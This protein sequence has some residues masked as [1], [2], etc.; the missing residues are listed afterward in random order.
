MQTVEQYLLE[1][2]RLGLAGE[3]R[4]VR[5]FVQEIL[6]LPVG[7]SDS[8][9]VD[10]PAFREA[11]TRLLLQADS[12][13]RFAR[14][15]PSRSRQSKIGS[16][17]PSTTGNSPSSSAFDTGRGDA[18]VDVAS[19]LPLT[20]LDFDGRNAPPVLPSETARQLESLIEER[21]RLRDLAKA[22][23]E[24]TRTVLFTGPPGVGKTMAARYMAS[25]LILPLITIDLAA[26]VSSFLGRTGQNLRQALEY[27]RSFPCVLLL[28]EF[29][30]LAKRRDDPTDVGELKRIVN[31]LL[32]ELEQW[33]A[34]GLLVAATNHPDLLDRAIWRRFE[35]V[36]VFP[37]PTVGARTTIVAHL[38]HSLGQDLPQERLDRF[39][40][41][42][43]QAS[44]SELERLVR[45]AARE[46]LLAPPEAPNESSIGR[47]HSL[48]D[49]LDLLALG[50]LERA[51]STN[52]AARATYAAVLT[53]V[54]GLSL[55]EVGERL[56]TSHT[57]VSKLIRQHQSLAASS[58]ALAEG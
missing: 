6:R 40:R 10:G 48:A 49:W 38:L 50:R 17:S 19:A 23:L 2:I 35:R 24:P 15:A 4:A 25:A 14:V 9:G 3:A 33:P 18:P 45:A 21:A 20:R 1:A 27:A 31:V 30:A 56:G 11:V 7:Q 43:E 39:V 58:P 22:G 44:G 47:P 5:Q 41:L 54:Y 42:S 13:M 32:L 12:A 37:M 16:V 52:E 46:W 36:I 26:V 51:A 53:E 29:D 57:T 34:T 55:R 28:D 8:A